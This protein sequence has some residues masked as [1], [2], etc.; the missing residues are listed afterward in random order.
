MKM[1]GETTSDRRSGENQDT[2]LMFNNLFLFFKCNAVYETMC[3]NIV[4]SDRPQMTIWRTRIACW[5]PKT[6]DTH[7]EYVILNCFSKPTKVARTHLFV[8][9]YVHCLPSLY[10]T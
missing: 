8:T 7:S 6:T 3:R 2:H 10:V 1:H 5:I 9:L 4:E